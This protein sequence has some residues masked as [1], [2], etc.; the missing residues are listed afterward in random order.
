MRH[1]HTME[2]PRED[3]PPSPSSSPSFLLFFSEDAKYDNNNNNILAFL[4][5]CS[6]LRVCVSVCCTV[7]CPGCYV[8]PCFFLSF[9]VWSWEDEG[10]RSCH[11][12]AVRRLAQ[13]WEGEKVRRWG[14]QS[15]V[16]W[17]LCYPAIDVFPCLTLSWQGNL[18]GVER[19]ASLEIVWRLSP[20]GESVKGR[21]RDVRRGECVCVRA[22]G[23]TPWQLL[24]SLLSNY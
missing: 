12:K 2:H 7:R 22:M 8:S 19:S 16:S 1:T 18:V 24:L 15:R 23:R 3:P 14:W 6:L 17:Y 11:Y 21:E 20:Q 4:C 13:R 9:C 10:E 5:S